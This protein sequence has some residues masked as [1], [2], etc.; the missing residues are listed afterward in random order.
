[1]VSYLLYV[2]EGVLYVGVKIM[3]VSFPFDVSICRST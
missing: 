1:M 3:T 2:D